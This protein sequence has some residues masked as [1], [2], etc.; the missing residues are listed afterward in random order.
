MCIIMFVHVL[1]VIYLLS[2]K[3]L[4]IIKIIIWVLINELDNEIEDF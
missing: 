4:E 1:N 3:Y 2:L